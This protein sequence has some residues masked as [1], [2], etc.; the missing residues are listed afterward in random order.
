MNVTL[1]CFGVMREYLP[2]GTAGNS[3]GLDVPESSTVGN[4]IDTL[5]APRRVVHAILVNEEPSDLSKELRDGD[6]LTLM[7]HYSGGLT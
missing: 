2:E 1:V 4:V 3:V 5:G 7:P 6:Q